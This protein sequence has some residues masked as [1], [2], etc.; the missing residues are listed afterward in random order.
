LCIVAPAFNEEAQIGSW[1][2]D[3]DR[4][5]SDQGEKYSSIDLV[6]VDDGSK[7]K[8]FE[9]CRRAGENLRKIKVHPVRLSRNFGHQAAITCGLVEAVGLNPRPDAVVTMDADGEH[10]I[11]IVSQLVDAWKAGELLVHTVREES[12]ELS[13]SKRFL[14][15]TFYSWIRKLTGLPIEPGMADFK[16]WDAALL[17][18]ILPYLD[19]CGAL[20]L[21][22]VYLA[23]NGKRVPFQQRV[24]QGRVSRFSFRKML[25]LAG[26]SVVF[27]SSAPMR[28]IGAIGFFS[29]VLALGLSAYSIVSV[30][31]NKTVPGWASVMV[32]LSFFSGANSLC[33]YLVAE[34]LLRVSF[35]SQLPVYVKRNR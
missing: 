17:A 5:F 26:Q 32:A 9:V 7:D 11:A 31:Q 15:R 8:T 1:I 33:L 2:L 24:I 28:L 12:A 23:P 16:L 4:F 6:V 3:V 25:S 14:S 34:Y 29:I 19:K 13:W 22:A 27:Y 35:R 20:R 18:S 21:F 10:P 30:F